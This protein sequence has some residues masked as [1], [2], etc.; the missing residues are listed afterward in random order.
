MILHDVKVHPSKDNLKREDQL[1]WKIA[2]V[3][4]DK[5]PVERD[6]AA[7]IVNR[8]IDNAAVAIAAINRRASMSARDMALGH[9]RKDGATVFGV[10]PAKRV[11]PG[12]GRVGERRR[13]ARTRHARHVSRRRLLASRRQHPADPRGRADDGEVRPRPDPRH[14]DRLRNPDRPGARD[15][16]ARAQDRP[17]RPS[18]PGAGRR[19]R[20]AARPEAGRDLPGGAAGGACQLHHAPVAQGRDQLLE[21]LRARARRQARDRGGRPRDARRGRAEPDL[22]RRGQR[23]RLDARRAGGA[24][25]GAAARAG[26]SRS[27]PS[28]TATPRSTAPN[29]RRR[30]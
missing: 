27:A 16:P 29:T 30:R 2:D 5:V 21:G 13:G 19:H 3:A 8:I 25:R 23:H 6:V 12:M 22:R 28:S 26:R 24:L 14:R 15:L 20:H 11:S 9:P 1:A 17:H 10:P 18:L 7:M 4:A